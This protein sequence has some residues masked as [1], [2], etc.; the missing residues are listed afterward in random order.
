[1]SQTVTVS[2]GSATQARK[3]VHNLLDDHFPREHIRARGPGFSPRPPRTEAETETAR[4][5]GGM[6]AGLGGM[7][8]GLI[9]LI[10]FALPADSGV[11]RPLVSL[12][13]GALLGALAGGTLGFLLG[14]RVPRR[15]ADGLE[16]RPI[17][18]AVETDSD[19]E[20][21]RAEADLL[22]VVGLFRPKLIA[23]PHAAHG[24]H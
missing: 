23:G 10:N 20:A 6:G 7:W 5:G 21:E 12:L 22:N 8:G 19:E 17:V 15:R 2:F 14:V 3:A 1:M 4:W 24:L 13:G 16:S 18:I 11:V 9:A